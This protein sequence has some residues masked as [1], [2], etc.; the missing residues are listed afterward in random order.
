[1]QNNN[2]VVLLQ[3]NLDFNS[4][5]LCN[6]NSSLFLSFFLFFYMELTS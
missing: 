4:F 1:M 3:K 5:K 2:F 6:N